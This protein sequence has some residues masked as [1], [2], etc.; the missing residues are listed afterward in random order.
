L[1][2]EDRIVFSELATRQSIWTIRQPMTVFV[3]YSFIININLDDFTDWNRMADIVYTL[4]Y[5][6]E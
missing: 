6:D 3:K 5:T 2:N 1:Q 4:Q